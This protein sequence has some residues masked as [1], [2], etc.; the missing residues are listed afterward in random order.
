MG[1]GE[2]LVLLHGVMGSERMWQDVAPLL[3]SEYDV[4]APTAYGHHGGEPLR[5]RPGTY[6]D[7]LAGAERQL[8][9]LGI[10]RA[11]LVGNSM[12]GWMA[13]DLAA[14]GPCALRL[15][16]LA[17]GILATADGGRERGPPHAA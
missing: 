17:G 5:K 4:I 10:E 14:K 8:D 7:V 13:L 9:S 11:H 3:A 12:G 6:S 15:R 2:P 16:D 1:S